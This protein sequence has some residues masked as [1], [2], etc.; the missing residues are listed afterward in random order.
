[1]RF[2]GLEKRM[3]KRTLVLNDL[4]KSLYTIKYDILFIIMDH[5]C[6]RG[7]AL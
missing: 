4:N 1:M 2:R 5:Y 6:I 3:E 7:S